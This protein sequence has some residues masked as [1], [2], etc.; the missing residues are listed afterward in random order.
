LKMTSITDLDDLCLVKIAKCLPFNDLI[1][2]SHASSRFYNLLSEESLIW[3]KGIEIN[4]LSM[5]PV[6]KKRAE[7]SSIAGCEQKKLFFVCQKIST[8]MRLGRFQAVQPQSCINCEPKIVDDSV[9][10]IDWPELRIA[11]TFK[12]RHIAIASPALTIFE[13]NGVTKQI[14]SIDFQVPEPFSNGIAFAGQ[15]SFEIDRQKRFAVLVV[16]EPFRPYDGS[17]FELPSYGYTPARKLISVVLASTETKVLQTSYPENRDGQ[18]LVSGEKVVLIQN[19]EIKFIDICSGAT[20][21]LDISGIFEPDSGWNILT[22]SDD[23]N[24]AV[25]GET[26]LIVDPQKETVRFVLEWSSNLRFPT[27][28]IMSENLLALFALHGAT[29]WNLDDGSLTQEEFW[30]DDDMNTEVS[31]VQRE[32]MKAAYMTIKSRPGTSPTKCR[33]T[34][35]Q[36]NGEEKK[37]D[38]GDH[39]DF[40]IF[41]DAYE[42]ESHQKAEVI[43]Q[44]FF[45]FDL[46]TMDRRFNLDFES[47][48]V[49]TRSVTT[50][51]SEIQ[52]YHLPI[53]KKPG[54]TNS[55]KKILHSETKFVVC[56]K[57]WNAIRSNYKVA[58]FDFS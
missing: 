42:N 21:S 17:G 27:R 13:Y 31:I 56:S 41:G 7:E 44:T 46:N 2:L 54:M 29:L 53:D 36:R 22:E 18:V 26:G 23:R 4:S 3:R 38:V 24:I 25:V 58:I 52:T 35:V 37:L 32:A 43:N 47:V 20:R 28:L 14:C 12:E 39:F 33:I 34:F 19:E 9:F 48:R 45:L 50:S 57:N 16:D 8:N 40:E 10:W 30:Q 11:R 51:Q 49:L 5:S 55:C 15:F 1:N 6:I